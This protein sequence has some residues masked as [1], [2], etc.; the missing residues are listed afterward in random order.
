MAPPSDPIGRSGSNCLGM[1]GN[2]GEVDAA[3]VGDDKDA[4]INFDGPTTFLWVFG[5]GVEACSG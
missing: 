1:K 2:D 5:E 3:L 4:T